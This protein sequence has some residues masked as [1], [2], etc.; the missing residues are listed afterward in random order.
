MASI[1]WSWRF[2][3]K[4]FLF[5]TM[6]KG[7]LLTTL[8]AYANRS[9]SVQ[10]A[11]DPFR[12]QMLKKTL[13]Y[14]SIL[15]NYEGGPKNNENFFFWRGE[16]RY[17]RLLPLGACIRDCPPNQ[18]AKRRPWGKV[19]RVCVIF[20]LSLCHCFRRFFDGRLKRTACLHQVLF[21]FGE[22]SRRNCHN[23]SRAF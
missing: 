5:A 19:Y 21:P 12:V 9:V 18:L 13:K 2:R 8:S 11:T 3:D 1:V 10:K 16:G 14:T 20:F 7:V 4:N 22:N 23:A 17:F 6:S 15:I